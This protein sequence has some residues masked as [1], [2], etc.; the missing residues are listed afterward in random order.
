M[1]LSLM[2]VGLGAAILPPLA[3]SLITHH[4]W[5]S[6]LAIIGGITLVL[7]VPAALV[8][9]RNTPGPAISP[10]L[11]EQMSIL[12][13]VG[14]R[15]FL[16]MCLIFLLLGVASVGVLVN[17]VPMMI[18]RGVTPGK[19]AELAALAGV[20]ALVARAGV[21]WV[22]DHVYAPRVLATFALVGTASFLLFDFARGRA[23]SLLAVVLLGLIVGAEVDCIG[24]MVRRY[25]PQQT[26][27]RLYGI[28]FGLI[29]VGT[30]T[31]PVL[32]SYIHD[33]SGAYDNGLLLFAV[34]GVVSAVITFALPR[35]EAVR[36]SSA[37]V[38]PPRGA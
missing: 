25:F 3:Q 13:M 15:A 28:A 32:L 27:G 26:F 38:L 24:F 10:Q 19:A 7:T 30:G 16:V 12:P 21:G 9:T 2:G 36:F 20:M 31:G 37:F 34:I 22:L 29:L 33:R 4:G 11:R 35:Y 1:G 5:R 18:E 8:T 14:T 17:L 6:A 23:G